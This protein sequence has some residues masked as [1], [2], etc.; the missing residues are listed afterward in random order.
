MACVE[1]AN[2]HAV[3]NWFRDNAAAIQALSSV[4]GLLVAGILAILT[5]RYVRVTRE[6]APLSLEQV[7]H[8][9]EASAIAQRNSGRALQ[10]LALRLRVGLGQLN[11]DVP[12]H[13]ELL[14]FASLTESDISDLEALARHVGDQTIGFASEAAAA[15]RVLNG[16]MLRAKQ[17]SRTQGWS[18][19]DKEAQA[20]RTEFQAAHRSLKAVEDA[21]SRL[22]PSA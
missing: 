5:W 6:I 22:W 18:A 4:A 15:L 17:V 21:C 19:N 2:E 20:W 11:S 10:C 13:S 1:A 7:K 12:R 14:S 3:M 9:R 16:V 8:I